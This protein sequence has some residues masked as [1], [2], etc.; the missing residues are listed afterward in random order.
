MVE[1]Y[2]LLIFEVS[3]TTKT[4]LI[5][6]KVTK[7]SKGIYKVKGKEETFICRHIESR[8]FNQRVNTNFWI[9]NGCDNLD[10]CLDS[11]SCCVAFDTFKQLKNWLNSFE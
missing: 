9:A 1:L 5:I 10:D 8:D 6:M 2:S 11:N 7:I 4:K 3:T